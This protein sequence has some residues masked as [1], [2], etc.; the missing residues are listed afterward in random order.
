M[1]RTQ[2]KDALRNISR[3]FI[4]FL[5]ILIVI[6]LGVGIFLACRNGALAMRDKGNAFYKETAYRD[7]EIRSVHGVTDEDIAV[8]AGQ[9][10]VETAEGIMALDLVGAGEKQKAAVHVISQTERLDQS[11]L[12]E[13]TMP[14]A[15]D[16]ALVGGGYGVAP[17]YFLA[18]TLLGATSAP[19]IALFV[20]GRSAPDIL[21]AEDFSALGVDVHVATQDGSLGAHGLVTAPLDQWLNETLADARHAT[22]ARVA[23]CACGPAPMLRA[24][25][26][27]A[28]RLG[29]PAWLSLD[30]RMAC[31][32]GACLGCVQRVRSGRG[33]ETTLARVCVDGPVFPAGKIVWD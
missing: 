6:S 3:Q 18:K 33:D 23:I 24:L 28:L 14:E 22:D 29:L 25:D 7:I 27:R 19:R 5:S 4:S 17:L 16:V 26:E 10:G 13:G 1:K 8:I 21:L 11:V 2:R 12:L 20:G 9:P 15:A 30:R 32:V 31:G